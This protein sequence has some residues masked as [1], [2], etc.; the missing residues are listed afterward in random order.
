[1]HIPMFEKSANDSKHGTSGVTDLPAAIVDCS[2]DAIV[3]KTLD[4]TIT[5]WNPAASELFGYQPEEMIGGP[6]RRLIPSDRQDEENRILARIKA[7]ERVQSYV[8]VRLDKEQRPI[9][10]SITVS[11]IWG[12]NRKIIGVSNIIRTIAS[13]KDGLE[14]LLLRQFVDQAPRCDH[15]A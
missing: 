8:T 15:D 4:G 10:V 13:Q 2:F 3:S 12:R 6:V 5:S 9:D 1:M 11:P 14:A 7:G